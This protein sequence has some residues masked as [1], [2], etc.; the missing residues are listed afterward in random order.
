[1][2]TFQQ[3]IKQQLPGASGERPKA[4]KLKGTRCPEKDGQTED[5]QTGREPGVHAGSGY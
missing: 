2:I 5:G 3:N 4:Q 1:M